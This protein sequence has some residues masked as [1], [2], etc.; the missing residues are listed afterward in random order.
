MP[1]T[2]SC[3]ERG[4]KVSTLSVDVSALL[5]QYEV[6]TRIGKLNTAG[7]QSN[8]DKETMWA[9]ARN[10]TTH[11]AAGANTLVNQAIGLLQHLFNIHTW[12]S[13]QIESLTIRHLR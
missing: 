1:F 3:L 6:F 2:R 12:L 4:P 5:K 7:V 13:D 9:A 10:S 8:K 11:L